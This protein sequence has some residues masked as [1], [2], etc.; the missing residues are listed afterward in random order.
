MPPPLLRPTPLAWTSIALR[1]FDAVLAD[2][3]HCEKKAASHAMALIAQYPEQDAL[4]G[5]L[6]A[7]AQ[8][9]L[10][11]FRQVVQILHKRGLSLGLD[12]GDP[13]VQALIKNCRHGATE[14]LVD[15]LLVA[16][17]VE[18]RS[19]ERLQMLADGLTDGDLKAFYARL[20]LAE[21]GHF[22]L[23]IRLAKKIASKAAVEARHAQ[24]LIYEAELVARLPLAA[25][26]H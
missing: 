10:R 24:W 21:A 6:A 13:Y 7:L 22:R 8:E 19:A 25:R 1:N 4:L 15:R 5:P 17:V 11:H 23:F 16:S 26:M 14:R 9:E 12:G 18:A 3:A 2:H 20:A